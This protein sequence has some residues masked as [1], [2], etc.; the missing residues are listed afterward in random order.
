MALMDVESP[1][2]LV[3]EEGFDFEPFF[4]IRAGL[5]N[6]FDVGDQVDGLLVVSP[7]PR[8]GGDGAIL[9][10][11]ESDE[12]SHELL[13]GLDASAHVLKGEFVILRGELDGRGGARDILPAHEV[14]LL[15]V[16]HS[17]EFPVSSEDHLSIGRDEGLDKVEELKMDLLGKMPLL[18]VPHDPCQ[19]QEPLVVDESDHQSGA[20]RADGTAIDGKY[21]RHVGQ[22]RN[23]DFGKGHKVDLLSD[24][25][26]D[27]QP[28][29]SLDPALPVGRFPVV[30]GFDG[31]LS[32][33]VGKTGALARHDAADHGCQGVQVPGLVARELFG[34]YPFQSISHCLITLQ[35]VAHGI[36][37]WF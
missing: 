35:N 24:G 8:Y 25:L 22:S 21:Q 31:S 36:P 4:V 23:E 19:G 32:G 10:P 11:G 14:D 6:G 20:S 37:L 30:V 33:N 18:A 15:L 7:P 27:Q 2:F 17:V 3:G 9:F 1:A 5:L 16:V 12:G 34:V 26:F 28:R 29:E 13:S